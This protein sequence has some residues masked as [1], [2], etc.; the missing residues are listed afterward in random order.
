MAVPGIADT[1]MITEVVMY[2]KKEEKKEEKK[3]GNIKSFST[4]KKMEHVD[5]SDNEESEGK[6]LSLLYKIDDEDKILQY[7]LI[8]TLMPRF[9][10]DS[11]WTTLTLRA[12]FIYNCFD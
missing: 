10:D 2:P 6:D 9:L 7:Q 1:I 11:N 8:V 12:R 3:D 5:D 4:R